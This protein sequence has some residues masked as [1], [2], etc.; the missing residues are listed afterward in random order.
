MGKNNGCSSRGP[1]FDSQHLHGGSQLSETPGSGSDVFIWS[2]WPLNE[3][4]AKIYT[5][6]IHLNNKKYVESSITKL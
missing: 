1:G 2:P 6:W 4:V 3:C 5:E